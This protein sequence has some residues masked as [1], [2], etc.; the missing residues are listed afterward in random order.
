MGL[1]QQLQKLLATYVINNAEEKLP[2]TQVVI[3]AFSG[4]VPQNCQ[5]VFNIIFSSHRDL[6]LEIEEADKRVKICLRSIELSDLLGSCLGYVIHNMKTCSS[7][8]N[9]KKAVQKKQEKKKES[10]SSKKPLDLAP[11]RGLDNYK[12]TGEI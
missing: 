3:S 4:D 6:D 12:R 8:H 7:L 5:S 1:N 9:V 2:N 10:A 11:V